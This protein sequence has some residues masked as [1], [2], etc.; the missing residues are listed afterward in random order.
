MKIYKLYPCIMEIWQAGCGVFMPNCLYSMDICKMGIFFLDHFNKH[1]THWPRYKTEFHRTVCV[2]QA[3][4]KTQFIWIHEHTW[5]VEK[6]GVSVTAISCLIGWVY[7]SRQDQTGFP[8]QRIEGSNT[9]PVFH[10]T[11]KVI[12]HLHHHCACL[13]W[14][15]H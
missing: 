4:K 2:C 7:I 14:L 5:T 9:S 8:T 3:K 15:T 11:T 10:H 6:W 12:C 13:I 1:Y